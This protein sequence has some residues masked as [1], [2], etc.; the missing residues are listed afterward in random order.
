MK[1]RHQRQRG[2][3][4]RR[5]LSH[6]L[7][8]ATRGT[9]TAWRRCACPARW[10]AAA[11]A[12][13]SARATA[14]PRSARW[15][16]RAVLFRRG[17]RCGARA[18]RCRCN[19]IRAR[20]GWCDA[21]ADRNYNRPVRHPYPAS[22]ERLWREDAPLRCRGR[23]RAT[24]TARAARRAAAPSSC[25]WPGPAMRRPR[26]ASP[27]ARDALCALLE[28]LRPGAAVEVLLARRRP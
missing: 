21:P 2:V 5:A 16:V 20:D 1:R 15:R 24:T 14:P 10:A 12:S 4:T 7:P 23:A 28:R 11:A 26:A 9:L 22:A 25:T 19:A 3:T 17:P 6:A 27:C 18:R 13:A 8:A